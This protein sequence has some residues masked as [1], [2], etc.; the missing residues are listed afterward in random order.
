M[1]SIVATLVTGALAASQPY[2]TP[3][4]TICFVSQ[5]LLLPAVN[6][7]RIVFSGGT[8]GVSWG[9]ANGNEWPDIYL[10]HHTLRNT[11]DRFP[12]SHLILDMGK[13]PTSWDH[14]V[15]TG[16][17]QHSALFIDIDGDGRE[18]VLETIG[19]MSGSADLDDRNS[20]NRLHLGAQSTDDPVQAALDAGVAAPGARGR[21]VVPLVHQA[22]LSLLEMN[23]R[24]AD[25][26][27]P[28]RFLTRRGST[29]EPVSV[30]FSTNCL[31]SGCFRKDAA[32][33]MGG[34]GRA[35]P[36][37]A[38][39]DANVDVIL[40]DPPKGRKAGLFM[41]NQD[42]GSFIHAA[43]LNTGRV[44]DTAVMD[45]NNDGRPEFVAATAKGL[46]FFEFGKSTKRRMLRHQASGRPVALVADDF[47]NDTDEDLLVLYRLDRSD[48]FAAYGDD[49]NRPL[50]LSVWENDGTGTFTEH[51]FE[52]HSHLGSADTA[53][54]GDL[55]LDGTLDVLIAMGHGSS[56]TARG[57]YLL[58]K[59]QSKNNWIQIDLR[60]DLGLKGLGAIVRATVGPTSMTRFQHGGVHGDVQDFQRL[61]FG[62]GNA[63]AVD[64]SVTWPDGSE[65]TH[66]A[67][68]ANHIVEIRQGDDRD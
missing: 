31:I 8:W 28:S 10:N 17:D 51:P 23:L 60:D 42:D 57:G 2:C 24:R 20:M 44:E 4:K 50:R 27:A 14:R 65:Q 5:S 45:R 47:D 48:A 6:G 67:I 43:D 15:L 56:E 37:H 12:E 68:E 58:L 33:D 63:S 16:A 19:G 29:F 61:H 64:I 66:K 38:N 32:H 1:L 55:D 7:N 26:L 53:T 13:E 18:D 22:G 11:N 3:S 62:L 36:I 25:G 59:G 35:V 40:L 49:P 21:V 46:V 39:D 9:D 54:V 41:Q 34:Y 30:F 52:D